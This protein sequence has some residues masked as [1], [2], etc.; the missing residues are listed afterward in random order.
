MNIE[1]I[2]SQFPAFSEPSLKGQ[3]F[4]ENA[5]GSYCCQQ[6]M[7][8][9]NGYY[10]KNKVQPYYPY[11]ASSG[12]GELMDAAYPALAEYLDVSADEIYLGPSTSQNT[13]VLANAFRDVLKPGDEIVVTNQDHEANSG[14]WRRLEKDGIVVRQ[15]SV[16]RETGSLYKEDLAQLLNDKTRLVMFP[17][18]SNILGAINP[19]A[20][21]TAMIHSAG[22]LSLVDGVSFAGH[23]LPDARELGAD[24]YLFSLYK[25]FGPHQGVM[26][27]RPEVAEAL[28]NQGH[29]FNGSYREKRL[30]PAGPDH[31]QVAAAQGVTEYFDAVFEYHKDQAK[32]Q[33]KSAFIRSLFHEAEQQP[34]M[35]L[36]DYLQSN[37]KLRVVGPKTVNGRAPTVSV[38]PQNCEP[39]ELVERLSKYGVMCG[40]GHFYSYRLLEALGIDP[41]RGVTRFSFVHYTSQ[42]ETE[43]LIGALDRVL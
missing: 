15:W 40:A 5:G 12:A 32:G 4:F 29:Y 17:H 10:R 8:R 24:V 13:Y 20:E 18:C 3:A 38:I 43:Q 28:G 39:W 33:N 7:D 25:T 21:Y 11:P 14:V 19:V 1:F 27:V 34:L 9:L 23:G 42:A 41:D 26:V 31:A 22:A 36:M 6:V 37:S 30:T 2:R 16:D 35:T